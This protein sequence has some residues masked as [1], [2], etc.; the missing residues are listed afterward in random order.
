[1][2][3]SINFT[4]EIFELHPQ[5]RVSWWGDTKKLCPHPQQQTFEHR[6]LSFK[7]RQEYQHPLRS[8]PITF[9]PRWEAQRSFRIERTVKRCTQIVQALP[10]QVSYWALQTQESP[11]ATSENNLPFLN[12]VAASI[13]TLMKVPVPSMYGKCLLTF[14]LHVYLKWF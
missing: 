10:G 4:F 14:K 12:F 6:I 2:E 1:M 5:K 13:P 8:P 7:L 3:K 11:P 9:Q